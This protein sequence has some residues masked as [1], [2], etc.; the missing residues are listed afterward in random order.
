MHN[1]LYHQFWLIKKQ[2]YSL[3]RYWETLFKSNKA[4]IVSLSKY[5]MQNKTGQIL[6]YKIFEVFVFYYI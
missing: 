5:V 2:M 4:K 6:K 1:V 3:R